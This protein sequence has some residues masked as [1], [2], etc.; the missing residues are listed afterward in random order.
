MSEKSLVQALE[1]HAAALTEN[2][3]AME[4][5]AQALEGRRM[6]PPQ[7]TPVTDT[8]PDVVEVGPI[9][10]DRRQGLFIYAGVQHHVSGKTLEALFYFAQRP[11]TL[12]STEDLARCLWSERNVIDIASSARSLMPRVKKFLIRVGCFEHF[13]SI[14][15]GR[16]GA[17]HRFLR[18]PVSKGSA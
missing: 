11:D 6:E 2:T 13:E 15:S 7:P 12:V 8:G 4:R 3:R 9:T 17:K 5:L 1:E 14:D 10:I 16:A 18:N